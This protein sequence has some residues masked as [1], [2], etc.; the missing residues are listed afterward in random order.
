MASIYKK[1]KKVGAKYFVSF[2]DDWLKVSKL[3]NVINILLQQICVQIKRMTD[4][5]HIST[6]LR[7]ME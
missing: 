4:K 5:H 2:I 3:L 1:Y 7:I 6:S